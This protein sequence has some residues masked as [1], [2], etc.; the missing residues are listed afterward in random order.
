MQL[1]G[2]QTIDGLGASPS[3]TIVLFPMEWVEMAKTISNLSPEA[4]QK[5]VDKVKVVEIEK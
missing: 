4:I 1:R 2:L 3:N 5:M